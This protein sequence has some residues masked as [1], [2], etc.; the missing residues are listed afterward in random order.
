MNILN[1]YFDKIYC[2]HLEETEEGKQPWRVERKT[3]CDSLFLQHEMTVEYV[4]AFDGADYETTGTMRAGYKAL[5]D[6]IRLKILS[7]AKQ[8]GYDKILILEDDIQFIADIMTVFE[9]NIQYIPVDVEA[10]EA[11]EGVE[12]V[13]AIKGADVLYGG[14]INR[15]HPAYHMGGRIWKVRRALLGHMLGISSTMFDP[16]N[17][18]LEKQENPSDL[19]LYNVYSDLDN[20][21][22]FAFMDCIGYQKADI[23]SD[24]QGRVIDNSFTSGVS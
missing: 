5:N 22:A 2:I 9:E 23:H 18:E 17:S 14:C 12:A 20:Y 16:W 15:P 3:E 6:T 1:E 11:A 8:Q 7:D 21:T 19:C 10:V 13:N 4:T 24:N